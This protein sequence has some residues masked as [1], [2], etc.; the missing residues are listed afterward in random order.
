MEFS[1]SLSAII[2]SHQATNHFDLHRQIK[3]D[4]TKKTFSSENAWWLA[5]LSRWMYCGKQLNADQRKPASDILARVDLE[6]T[7]YLS[8]MGTD[9]CLISAKDQS[10]SVLVFRGTCNAR[11]WLT[12]IN[13][14]P[15]CNN[16]HR[17][18]ERA[19]DH[20]WPELGPVLAARS[21]P[22]FFTGHS[23][24]GALATL[25][26]RRHKPQAVYSFG[27]PPIG[28]Q[29]LRQDYQDIAVYRMVNFKDVVSRIPLA[30]NHVG[31]LCYLTQDHGIKLD[32]TP[33][34][35]QQDQRLGPRAVTRHLN[36]H[37]VISIP[38]SLCDHAPQN[39]TAHCERLSLGHRPEAAEDF[40]LEAAAGS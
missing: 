39:Y 38:E 34:I 1:T 9:C 26:A 30:S 23:M 17:G 27:S 40:T 13:I 3:F 22:I 16:A 4:G 21:E 15:F 20:L 2:R 12:N 37:Q 33:A 36:R 35:V 32:P 19:L 7:A 14:G 10:F 5:E 6:E 11:N 28:N 29:R 18:Y 24:G 31:T 8:S 25:A